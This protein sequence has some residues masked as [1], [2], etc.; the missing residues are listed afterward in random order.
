MYQEDYDQEQSE[1]DQYFEAY[2][3]MSVH[4]VMLNDKPR[5]NFYKSVLAESEIKNHVVV[6]VGAGSGVLSCWAAKA[7]AKHVFSIEAS[8]IRNILPRIF[9]EN[10]IQDVVSLLPYSVEQLVKNGVE[11]FIQKFSF[12]KS[13]PTGVSVIVS[14]WMGF[15]LLHEGMLEAVLKARDFFVEVNKALGVSTPIQLIPSKG[16][17]QAAP[18]SLNPLHDENKKKWENIYG[19]NFSC[20][21]ALA[22]EEKLESSSPVIET[23][24]DSCLIHEGQEACH[25]DFSS[26]TCDELDHLIS[27]C[28]F[29]FSTSERFQE[30]LLQSSTGSV[31]VDGILVWFSV[32]Y[33]THTLDTS[34]SSPPTHWKQTAILLPKEYRDN[35]TVSFSA[36]DT[37]PLTINL[38]MKISDNYKRCYQISYELQ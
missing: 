11:S 8:S 27:S 24:P 6:D 28:E 22:L 26:M 12:L 38:E 37:D 20:L 17:I 35:K 30:I 10:C 25:F 18:I 23:F 3:S 7:G 13:H 34:P 1:D 21:G 9:E 15:Y 36:S 4:E 29:H 16:S 31:S 32:S 2:N 19:L 14:E 5:M 33:K